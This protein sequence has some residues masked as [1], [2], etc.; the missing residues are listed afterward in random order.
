M[1]NV[2]FHARVM[3]ASP[4]LNGSRIVATVLKSKE[5]KKEWEDTLNQVIGRMKEM[6]LALKTALDKLGC[7]P[8][9]G[10]KSWDHITSQVGMFCFTGLSTKQCDALVKEYDI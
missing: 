4:P 2:K 3:Y 9:K 10:L 6:R 8:P 7:E 5:L 1:S